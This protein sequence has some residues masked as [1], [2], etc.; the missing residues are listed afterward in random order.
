M[1][2]RDKPTQTDIAAMTE[3]LAAALENETVSGALP[4]QPIPIMLGVSGLYRWSQSLPIPQPIPQPIPLPIPGMQQLAGREAT[5]ETALEAEAAE[6]EI[7]DETAALPILVQREE[8]RL[9]VDGRYPQMAASGTIYRFGLR[10][11]MHWIA[12]LRRVAQPGSLIVLLSDF[13][14]LDG[15]G[16]A[17]LVQLARHSELILADIHDPLEAELPP[18]GRVKTKILSL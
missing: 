6:A 9:D 4:L 5:A 15:Q 11:Q 13:G 17:H 14:Q 3:A 2:E 8:L 12:R 18:P 7:E 10:Q 16:S 1:A